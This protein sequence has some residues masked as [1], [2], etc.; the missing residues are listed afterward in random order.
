MV[1]NSGVVV[2]HNN[3][4]L[5]KTMYNPIDEAKKDSSLEGLGDIIT[6]MT[7]GNAGSGEYYF[8][9]IDKFAGFAPVTNTNWSIAVV[10]DKK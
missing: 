1:N 8:Q 2:A 10:A 3:V 7:Q 6:K 9:G 5:V 4:E